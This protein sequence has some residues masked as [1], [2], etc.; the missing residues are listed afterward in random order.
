[1]EAENGDWQRHFAAKL[2]LTRFE[3]AKGDN[4]N[5]VELYVYNNVVNWIM[6]WFSLDYE[7]YGSKV[8]YSETVLQF[9]T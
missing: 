2:L 1:M 4:N 5:F 8:G 9:Q 3:L 6:G 7:L